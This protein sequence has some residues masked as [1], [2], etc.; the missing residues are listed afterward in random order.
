[1]FKENLVTSA[2]GDLLSVTTAES[3]SS[4]PEEKA[5]AD[6]SPTSAKGKTTTGGNR[7]TIYS[8]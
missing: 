5:Q 8:L 4:T 1:M 3:P 6:T 7:Y 2:S